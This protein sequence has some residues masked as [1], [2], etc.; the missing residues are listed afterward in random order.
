MRS[1]T[2]AAILLVSALTIPAIAQQRVPCDDFQHNQDG[3]WTPKHSMTLKG[4]NGE[5][6]IE[7]TVSFRSGTT[8][9]G[10]DLAEILQQDCP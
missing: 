1:V 10:I 5:V 7:P 9:M 6:R 3:S 4:P 8:F 2:A